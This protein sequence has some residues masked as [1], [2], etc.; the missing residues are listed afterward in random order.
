MRENRPSG[1]EAGVALIPPSL[2]L[3]NAARIRRRRAGSPQRMDCGGLPPLCEVARVERGPASSRC[4]RAGVEAGLPT[5]CYHHGWKQGHSFLELEEGRC[6]R[7][8]VAEQGG[9]ASGVPAAEGR[10]ECVTVGVKGWA[11]EQGMQAARRIRVRSS[12]PASF[13]VWPGWKL[14]R[15]WRP[16]GAT[17]GG[18][19]CLSGRAA[20]PKRSKN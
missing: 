13:E 3:S 7:E 2:P 10:S 12:G 20:P 1:S 17:S 9:L 6:P 5:G 8:T 4:H 19:G 15:A 18:P 14:S 11:G 16:C